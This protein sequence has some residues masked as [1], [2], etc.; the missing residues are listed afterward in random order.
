MS[1]WLLDEMMSRIE[2][3]IDREWKKRLSNYLAMGGL[4]VRHECI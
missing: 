2:E 3:R 4:S 1:G